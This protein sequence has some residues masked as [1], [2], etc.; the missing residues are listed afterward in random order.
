MAAGSPDN[1]HHVR[2]FP[3]LELPGHGQLALP[4]LGEFEVTKFMILQVFAGL[5]TLL[6]F[7][8]LAKRVQSG[9]PT[10]GRWWNFWE[11]VALFIRDEVVRPTIG[12]GHHGED[13]HGETDRKSVV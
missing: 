2:D 13:H 7:R 8:G 10:R 3:Y 11:S 5:L 9:E 4:N 1:F 12:D 6:I